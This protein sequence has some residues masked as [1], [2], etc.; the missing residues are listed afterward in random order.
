MGAVEIIIV[1]ENLDINRWVLKNP[2]TGEETVLHLSPAKEK[3]KSFL[4]DKESG[5]ELEVVESTPFLEWLANNYKSFGATLEIISDRSQEG[6]Q[7][8]SGFNGMGGL[9]RYQV[10]FQQLEAADQIY[11]DYGA[12]DDDDYEDYEDYM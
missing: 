2:S 8:V 10:D 5:C 6:S 7:F 3:D 1:Y 11:D 12:I 9:L 4:I